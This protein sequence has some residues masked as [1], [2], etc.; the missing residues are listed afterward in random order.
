M[1]GGRPNRNGNTGRLLLAFMG[2]VPIVVLVAV[3]V[4]YF[5]VRAGFGL[6]VGA[7]VPF[8][9]STMIIIGLGVALGRA[10][11]GS[12]GSPGD[13]SDGSGGRTRDRD[14]V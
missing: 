14:G 8:V 5:L 11:S 12:G 3:V 9:V 10:A 2:V 13:R 4:A 1:S 7:G 6:L